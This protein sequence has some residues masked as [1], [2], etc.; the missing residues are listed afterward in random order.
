M[1]IGLIGIA[2]LKGSGKDT[3][4]E[5]FLAAEWL[6]IRFADPIKEMLYSLLL[7]AWELDPMRWIDGD[8]KEE[9]C[10]IL[11]GRTMRHAMQTLGTEWGREQIDIGLW[12]NIFKKRVLATKE[13]IVCTDVRFPQEVD[14]IHHLNGIVLRVERPGLTSDG[15]PSEE[16][17]EH[18]A[19]DIIVPNDK[20]V[21]FLHAQARA[22]LRLI[23]N[24]A[25]FRARATGERPWRL[26]TAV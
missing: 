12:T 5:T 8:W 7:L 15:H 17:V 3:F 4:A 24:H 10:H 6:R 20:D 19:V 9:P 11:C 21:D 1:T 26:D 18:L 16:S 2:G 14:I 13:K 23:D 25:I 22:L